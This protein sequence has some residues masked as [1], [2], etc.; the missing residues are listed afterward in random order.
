M[1]KLT[2]DN[3]VLRLADTT[4]IPQDVGS[5][6][7]I[8]Y[9]AWL[10]EGNTPQPA[11][12]PP[13]AALRADIDVARDAKLLEGVLHDGVRF[14]TDARFQSELG[15]TLALYTEG[16]LPPTATT[17]IRTKDNTNIT[18]TRDQLR[19]LA[20][21]VAAYVKGVYAWSWAEKDAL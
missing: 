5:S 13:L 2:N 4:Y 17:T 7:Y 19:V 16:I 14:H 11:D 12:P 6:D 21:V 15:N 3:N 9:L 10:A 20:G 1:Y 18:M 8:A